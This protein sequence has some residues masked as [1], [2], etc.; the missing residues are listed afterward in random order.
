ME[1]GLAATISGIF[2]PWNWGSANLHE[3]ELPVIASG[4]MVRREGSHE[5]GMRLMLELQL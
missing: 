3:R 5:C 1:E 2:V 4:E